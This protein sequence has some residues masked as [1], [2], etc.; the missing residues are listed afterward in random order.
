[1][2]EWVDLIKIMKE[3]LKLL[4][5]KI[6]IFYI[7]IGEKRVSSQQEKLREWKNSG[8]LNSL[9]GHSYAQAPAISCSHLSN[10]SSDQNS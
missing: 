7:S 2:N 9:Q 5:E 3:I 8:N 1:M 4:L 10:S 6:L